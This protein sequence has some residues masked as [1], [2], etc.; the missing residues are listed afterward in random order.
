MKIAL[1]GLALMA[2]SSSKSTSVP[3]FHDFEAASDALICNARFDC[4]TAA[5]AMARDPMQPTAAACTSTLNGRIDT[6]FTA[7]ET[8]IT[9]GLFVYNATAGGQCIDA[10]TA[11]E[12]DC[13]AELVAFDPALDICN[14]VIVGTL[15]AGVACDG[16]VPACG[17]GLY[18]TAF[19]T[20]SG[21]CAMPAQIG[22]ACATVPCA[23][24]LTC[25]PAGTC[26]AVLDDGQ[27]C[28]NLSQCKSGDCD[29]TT[30]HNCVPQTL[31]QAVCS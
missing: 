28:T 22:Q 13:S 21:T 18:C 19:G 14:Q 11:A 16:A 1:F 7:L 4:C 12:A 5:V 31:E 30:T 23:S 17:P 15:A 8:G 26:G 2:C 27:A 29:T 3:T 9:N 6:T 20:G 25:L 24:G 10:R